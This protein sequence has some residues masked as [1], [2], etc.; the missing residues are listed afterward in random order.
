M[1][2]RHNVLL[3]LSIVPEGIEKGYMRMLY[4]TAKVWHRIGGV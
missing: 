1:M 3:L 2:G 4:L